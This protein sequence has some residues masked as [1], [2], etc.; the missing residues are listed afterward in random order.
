MD[1]RCHHFCRGWPGFGGS[2]VLPPWYLSLFDSSATQ[3]FF[4]DTDH[5]VLHRSDLRLCYSSNILHDPTLVESPCPRKFDTMASSFGRF[6]KFHEFSSSL[7]IV[8]V[9]CWLLGVLSDH[10]SWIAHRA[11]R[12][13]VW[14][15]CRSGG[16][17]S[18][19]GYLEYHCVLPSSPKDT[20]A[21][22]DGEPIV[23]ECLVS[24]DTE[25]QDETTSGGVLSAQRH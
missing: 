4:L 1:S 22:V 25:L 2:P 8:M 7:D 3:G 17:D 10:L 21:N 20:S 12:G 19:P 16:S 23:L 13:N 6:S 9:S 18:L 14:G 15:V 5:D 11:A 24:F